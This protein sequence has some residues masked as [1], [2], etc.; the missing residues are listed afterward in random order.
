MCVAIA[1]NTSTGCG[2]GKGEWFMM[3][4]V[5]GFRDMG[6]RLSPRPSTRPN[7]YN[8]LGRNDA[9][10]GMP[11][12]RPQGHQSCRCRRLELQLWSATI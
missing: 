7:Y 12:S 5:Y 8:D 4:S 1:A 10:T 3:S 9:V 11:H 6:S 2:T